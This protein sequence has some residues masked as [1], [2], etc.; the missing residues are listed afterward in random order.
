MY[1]NND[2]GRIADIKTRCKS[3]LAKVM[4]HGEGSFNSDFIASVRDIPY[5]LE[6]LE[7]ETARAD[8]LE[9]ALGNER[10]HIDRIERDMGAAITYET[11]RIRSECDEWKRRAKEAESE[12]ARLRQIL[13]TYKNFTPKACIKCTG[14]PDYP[15]C[16]CKGKPGDDYPGYVFD[17]EQFT[18]GSDNND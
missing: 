3:C 16:A 5:L 13:E 6:A 18:K 1:D 15:D 7:A 9:I 14:L 12:V 8:E 4:R 11:A 17:V 10:S 2:A